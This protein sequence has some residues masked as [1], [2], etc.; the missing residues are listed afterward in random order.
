MVP[1]SAIF[2]AEAAVS[3][4][5]S[6]SPIIFINNK[7]TTQYS[8]IQLAY[9]HKMLFTAPI[10]LLLSTAFAIPFPAAQPTKASI[11]DI[12]ERGSA[13]SIEPAP[14]VVAREANPQQTVTDIEARAAAATGAFDDIE[15]RAAAATGAFNDIEARAAAATGAAAAAATGGSKVRR[16]I[17]EERSVWQLLFG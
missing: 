6:T 11:F 3:R 1:L 14:N 17:A 15:A 8:H 4:I 5:S 2:T 13:P 12:V 7:P 16:S 9:H 10:L